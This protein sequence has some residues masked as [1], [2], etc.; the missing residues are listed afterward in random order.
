MKDRTI[1]I[2]IVVIS[3]LGN[4]YFKFTFTNLQ[5][6]ENQRYMKAYLAY[7][8]NI[9]SY[10]KSLDDYLQEKDVSYEN[11]TRISVQSKAIGIY[12]QQ[13]YHYWA[14]H[15]LY[16]YTSRY[17]KEIKFK[18]ATKKLQDVAWQIS[19]IN[20][21]LEM[22]IQEGDTE[23]RKIFLAV[24]NNYKTLEK[25]LTSWAKKIKEANLAM[26]TEELIKSQEDLL[27]TVQKVV[28]LNVVEL[29]KI[30]PVLFEGRLPDNFA[31]TE[32]SFRRI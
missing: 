29:Y 13:L 12:S 30:A 7:T 24:N 27:P 11:R 17:I 20:N 25:E 23:K 28:E 26:T 18:Q 14:Y 3:L 9:S 10:I 6:L 19:F 16:D 31:I 5:E 8:S 21:Q 15:E 2:C 1:F 4:I 32:L 22:H